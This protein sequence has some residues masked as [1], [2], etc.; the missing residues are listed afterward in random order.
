MFV[1]DGI[2]FAKECKT[3]EDTSE[4]WRFLMGWP[5]IWVTLCCPEQGRFCGVC[6]HSNP[7]T[8]I[9]NPH[10]PSHPHVHLFL[11]P[12]AFSATLLLTSLGAVAMGLLSFLVKIVHIPITEILVAPVQK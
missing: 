7:H 12:A 11:D 6:P 10:T 9:N 3:G 5:P 8:A 1:A 4:W 2:K